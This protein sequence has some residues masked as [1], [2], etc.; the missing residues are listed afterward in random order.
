MINIKLIVPA[1]VGTAFLCALIASPAISATGNASTT[2]VSN[3][4]FVLAQAHEHD[5]DKGEKS[6]HKKDESKKSN[7]DGK[8]G[9]KTE[10]YA[11]LITSHADALALTDEQ[12]GKITR[13][14]MKTKKPNK[15]RTKV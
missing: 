7:H 11:H 12:L 3:K 15:K 13:I 1:V 5:K 2:H 10:D 9:K 8:H 14:H 6:N 4:S